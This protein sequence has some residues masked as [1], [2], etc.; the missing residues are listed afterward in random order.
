MIRVGTNYFGYAQ[1]RNFAGLPFSNTRFIKVFDHYK[2]LAFAKFKL[3]KKVDYGLVNRFGYAL[4]NKADV[5]HF[6]NAISRT[7]KP[8]VVTFET[9]LPRVRRDV[10]RGLEH[11]AGKHC[12][13]VIALSLR[14][15]EAQL[16]ELRKHPQF[17]AAIRSKLCVLQPSQKLLVKDI[18]GK[19]FSGELRFFFLGSAFY[20]KGGYELLLAFERLSARLPI[21][22]IVVSKLEVQGFRD[23]NITEEIKARTKSLLENSKWVDHHGY[24][25]NQQALAL[26]KSA[27]VGMLPSF[28]ES[29]GYSLLEAMA[30]GCAV[31]TINMSPFTEFVNETL[32]WLVDIPKIHLNGVEV[33]EID[34]AKKYSEISSQLVD[35]LCDVIEKICSDRDLLREKSENALQR[36]REFHD[37]HKRAMEL[38]NIYKMALEGA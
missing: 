27:H 20:G 13:K 14:A 4:P 3:F 6:F 19:D 25:P 37:P 31:V 29:Y 30:S 23:R 11:L 1:V 36:V 34:N 10:I 17:E 33:V 35:G 12:K 28:G 21:R 24:L 26:M 9:S 16:H 15:Y 5:Y 7:R 32:G 8:W 18:S 38:E 2:L 22:L